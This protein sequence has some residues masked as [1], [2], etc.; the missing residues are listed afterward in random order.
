LTHKFKA[1]PPFDNIKNIS[2]KDPIKVG[3]GKNKG[4]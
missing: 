3:R 4:L 1:S 2:F